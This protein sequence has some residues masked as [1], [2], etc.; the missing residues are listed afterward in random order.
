MYVLVIYFEHLSFGEKIKEKTMEEQILTTT[1]QQT[2]GTQNKIATTDFFDQY[3]QT[4]R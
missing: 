3:L 1:T 2:T 4:H